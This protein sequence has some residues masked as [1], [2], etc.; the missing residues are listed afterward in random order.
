MVCNL[1]LPT[2]SLTCIFCS[3]IPFGKLTKLVTGYVCSKSS[4][5]PGPPSSVPSLLLV[6]AFSP[7]S[8]LLQLIN[9]ISFPCNAKRASSPKT[10]SH[11]DAVQPYPSTQILVTLSNPW[12][13]LVSDTTRGHCESVARTGVSSRCPLSDAYAV[14]PEVQPVY[15][16]VPCKPSSL[17][18]RTNH[19]QIVR[20]CIM[21]HHT[22]LC[23]KITK[24]LTLATG[25]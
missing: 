14:Q 23:C 19:P 9:L 4:P 5:P 3:N 17:I 24:L 13:I 15:L 7:S 20:L 8:A 1:I 16:I 6:L 12:W 11:I 21:L 22:S 2:Q 18:H 25:M 10:D